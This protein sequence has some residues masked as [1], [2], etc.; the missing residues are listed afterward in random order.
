MTGRN[1]RA[2][3]ATLSAAASIFLAGCS[4]VGG[5]TSGARSASTTDCAQIKADA[6]AEFRSGDTASTKFDWLLDDLSLR[7]PAE[8][9]ELTDEIDWS[10]LA[11]S[12]SEN[13][14]GT[15]AGSVVWSDAKEHVGRTV[16]VCGPL[17]NDGTS[18]D[19]VFLNLGRGYP[20]KDRFTIVIWDV[21][22]IEEVPRGTTLC[23]TGVVS[24]YD[25]VAQIELHDPG[26]VKMLLGP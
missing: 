25:S 14:N 8:Y 15:P 23:T 5:T 3:L 9:D 7:C 4:P 10:S 24:V 13:S 6:Q 1:S 26:D 22:A 18:R 17:V 21:G 20:D 2:A 19:D 12:L 16:T 11:P